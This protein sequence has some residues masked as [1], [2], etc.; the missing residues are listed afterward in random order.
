[1][2]DQ[3]RGDSAKKLKGLAGEA[4]RRVDP[5]EPPPRM[6]IALGD[7][8]RTAR[9]HGLTSALRM[10]ERKPDARVKIGTKELIDFSSD[11]Y[12][13]LAAD[14]RLAAA[15]ASALL[16]APTGT[17]ASRDSS[18]NHPLHELLQRELAQYKRTEAALLF[19]SADTAHMASIPAI[20]GEADVVYC[21]ELTHYSLLEAVRLSHA[22]LRVFPHLAINE[23]RQQLSEDAGTYRRQLIAVESVFGSDADFFPLDR[24]VETARAHHAWTYV[25]ESHAT[26][27]IGPTGRGLTELFDVENEIDIVAGALDKAL[28]TEGGFVAGRRPVID[29]FGH[30]SASFLGG[31]APPP[32]ITAAALEA[33]HIAETDGRGRKQLQRN[34]ER[35]YARLS[36]VVPRSK[37]NAS[38][39]T[40][41]FIFPV[42]IGSTEDAAGIEQR[43]RERG[44]LVGVLRPT[45]SNDV[46]RLRITV[47][48]VHNEVD[49]DD[50]ARAAG[51]ELKSAAI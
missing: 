1:M 14:A 17:G 40:A 2:S 26:G 45:G 27:V 4:A 29:F 37:L 10:V 48:A 47:T 28:G 51:E 23:L 49:I 33:L 16:T 9:E 5:A 7:E 6:E 3:L 21:D 13:G 39:H 19:G 35:L 8:L 44:F 25:D 11:D 20:V 18:G 38:T 31:N 32:P 34:A 46:A 50:F 12:L 42:K 43:L 15:A 36:A 24:L 30:T 22:E 41:R